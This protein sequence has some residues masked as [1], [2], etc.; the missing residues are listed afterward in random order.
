M[1]TQRN[2]VEKKPKYLID[3]KWWAETLAF[4]RQNKELNERL[5]QAMLIIQDV[6]TDRKKWREYNKKWEK[7]AL[8]LEKQIEELKHPNPNSAF[9]KQKTPT[10]EMAPQTGGRFPTQT[11]V[12]V[13]NRVAEQAAEYARKQM[14]EEISNFNF[15]GDLPDVKNAIGQYVN[16][17]KDKDTEYMDEGILEKKTEP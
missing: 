1:I 16:D 15:S 11:E 17:F 4:M 3:P 5:F 12:A 2:I 7:Y 13:L 9:K 14:W 10:T 8:E 6:N